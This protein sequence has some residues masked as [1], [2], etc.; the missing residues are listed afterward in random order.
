MYVTCATPNV[1]NI[2]NTFFIGYIC[3]I[4]CIKFIINLM[5]IHY[6]YRGFREEGGG[7]NTLYIISL[8]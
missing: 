6:I 5:K 4:L 2:L 7:G 3:Y 1:Y 8:Y